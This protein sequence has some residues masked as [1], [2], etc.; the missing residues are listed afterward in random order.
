MSEL[1][2]HK[3][4]VSNYLLLS[5]TNVKICRFYSKIFNGQACLTMVKNALIF[6][7]KLKIKLGNNLNLLN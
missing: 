4:M 6:T 1:N 3:P 7:L 5:N 2:K